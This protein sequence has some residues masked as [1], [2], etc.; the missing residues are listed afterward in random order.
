M[1]IASLKLRPLLVVIATHCLAT[2]C[3]TSSHAADGA[4]NSAPKPTSPLDCEKL[5]SIPNTEGLGFPFAG[6]HGNALLV[7]GGANFPNGKP[8]EGGKKVWHDTVFVLESLGGKWKQ[9]GKLPRP[10]AYG[11]SISTPDGIACLGGSDAER[12]YA[13]CFLL[14]WSR[15]KLEVATL[16]NLPKPCANFTGV[17]LEHTIYVA[18]GIESPMATT[19]LHSFWS[20]DLSRPDA[21]W[22][23]LEPWPG[24][25]RM[26]AT[27]GGQGGALYLF[28]GAGLKANADGEAERQWLTDAYRF[29]MGTDWKQI[30]NLPR[31]VVAA[32]TPAPALGQSQL[33]LLG[34][35]D[36]AQAATSPDQH[37]GFPRDILAYH[38]V[39]N[40][41]TTIGKLP[42]SYATTPTANWHGRIIV[43]GGET[44]PG[45]RSNEAW[46][47]R[48]V[49]R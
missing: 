41:W 38:T 26:F 44:R 36:G 1:S 37:R 46:V 15:G 39:T 14:K 33:L 4:A 40:R 45:I 7:A 42:F 48:I 2:Q 30:A 23:E 32:P 22:R 25:G 17:L 35:D 43:P 13:D 10:L 49:P 19:A 47:A 5:A 18:G 16:P 20:L 24:P 21:T 27:M 8:W 31:P 9:A 28:G 6:V 29:E 3:A 11:V 34:G 12:H